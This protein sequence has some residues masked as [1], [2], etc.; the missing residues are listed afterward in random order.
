MG[1]Y[2]TVCIV[3]VL[4]NVPNTSGTYLFVVVEDQ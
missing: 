4:R 2:N 1:E 3:C